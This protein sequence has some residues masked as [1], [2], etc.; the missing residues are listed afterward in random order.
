MT[1]TTE[2]AF[3]PDMQSLSEHAQAHGRVY[4]ATIVL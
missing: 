4:D 2:V 1:M 3:S